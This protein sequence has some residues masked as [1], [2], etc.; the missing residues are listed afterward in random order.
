MSVAPRP[1]KCMRSM[2][3]FMV[4]SRHAVAV[5][6]RRDGFVVYRFKWQLSS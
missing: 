6:A 2:T 3:K 5:K 4:A 1:L